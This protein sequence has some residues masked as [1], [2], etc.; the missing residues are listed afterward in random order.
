M[1]RKVSF[2]SINTGTE[3]NEGNIIYREQE[4]ERSKEKILLKPIIQN[5]DSDDF[6]SFPYSD[7]FQSI[8][9]NSGKWFMSSH[10]SDNEFI[11]CTSTEG[12][13]E[14]NAGIICDC[15][16]CR[17]H[18]DEIHYSELEEECLCDDC[19]KWIDERD[20]ICREENAIYNNYSGSYHY[21]R[22]LDT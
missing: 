3:D 21:S 9:R 17:T 18:E 12:E 22:D 20:D 8:G 14:N 2:D 5:F 19:G 7:T 10:N 11:C 4:T 15:C 1:K 16:D 6:D 13:D